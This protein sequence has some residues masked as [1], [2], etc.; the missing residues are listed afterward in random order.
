MLKTKKFGDH[1][2]WDFPRTR[3]WLLSIESWNPWFWC[4]DGPVWVVQELREVA[5]DCTRV[6]QPSEVCSHWNPT[7][8]WILKSFKAPRTLADHLVLPPPPVC[9]I[10]SAFSEPSAAAAGTSNPLKGG[11]GDCLEGPVASLVS[12]FSLTSCISCVASP[13]NCPPIWR[14]CH[15]WVLA[16]AEQLNL[17]IHNQRDY[18]VFS[19][20]LSEGWHLLRPVS[21]IAG[22]NWGSRVCSRVEI[23]SM[24]TCCPVAGRS[25]V[26][27]LDPFEPQT[28]FWLSLVKIIVV[29]P[30]V[31]FLILPGCL[32]QSRPGVINKGHLTD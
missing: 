9:G 10:R 30:L 28:D 12:Q 6:L 31:H 1:F 5:L 20:D 19:E 3:Q 27:L 26:C 4:W 16:A 23:A 17:N 13:D 24:D 14:L 18:S 29:L 21:E 7:S 22:E 11:A 2:L 25:R 15:G 32:A 8:P